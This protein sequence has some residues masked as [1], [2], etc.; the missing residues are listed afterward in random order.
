[1][2]NQYV[3]TFQSVLLCKW[4]RT[5]RNAEEICGGLSYNSV[6]T[7]GKGIVLVEA[8]RNQPNPEPALSSAWTPRGSAVVYTSILSPFS[9]T[10]LSLQPKHSAGTPSHSGGLQLPSQEILPFYKFRAG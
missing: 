6:Q 9:F 7:W 8:K 3:S 5:V 2:Q 4:H 10:R 1:M